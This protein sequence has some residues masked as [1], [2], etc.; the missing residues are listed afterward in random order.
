MRARVYLFADFLY[1]NSE[2]PVVGT[3]LLLRPA[4]MLKRFDVS[5]NPRDF[6]SRRSIPK[7][8]WGM[9]EKD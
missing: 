2:P 4:D 6:A 8:L 9:Y 1:S 5:S 3:S 7:I